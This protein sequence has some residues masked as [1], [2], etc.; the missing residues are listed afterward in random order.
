LSVVFVGLLAAPLA[1]K[2]WSGEASGGTMDRE[3]ALER[4]G[5]VLKNV[6]KEVGIDFTHHAPTLD[7]SLSHIMPEVAQI[8]ASVSV[9]DYDGDGYS[10]LYV[11][12][13]KYGTENALYRN[14]GDG[15]FKNVAPE[16]GL[17]D[18][19]RR[20]MGT[21]MGSVWGDYDNDGDEDLFLYK[22]G[23][24]KLFRNE[25]GTGFTDV[26]DHLKGLPDWMN[27]GTAI[28]LDANQDGFLDLFV[29]GFYPSAF[30]LWNLETTRVMPESY[31][32][33]RNGGQNHLFLNQGDGT[34]REA[35]EEWGLTDT[36][37]TLAAAA[38]DFN[39]S[40]Y[41]DLFIA[42]DFG[43]DQFFVNVEGKRFRAASRASNVGRIPES[44]MNASTGDVMNRGTQALYVS[45]L[46]EEGVLV[47]GNNLWMAGS[48]ESGAIPAFDNLAG[49]MG[50]AQGGWSYGGQFGDLNNDG[51]QD[52]IVVNGFY[53]GSKSASYWYDFSKVAGGNED[54]IANAA[55]WPAMEG[56]SLSGHQQ[57]RIWINDGA[58]QF[59]NVAPAVGGASTHDGRAV[60]LADLQNRGAP[61]AVIANQRGPVEVYRNTVDPQHDWIAFDLTG[62][63][64]NRSAI[65]ARVTLHWNDQQQVQQVHGG[66]GFASQNQR[67]VHFGLGTDPAVQKAVIRWPSGTTQ[68][69]KSPEINTIHDVTEP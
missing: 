52:L 5:F 7:S 61:D 46:T 58:G 34:F 53:S 9:S 63:E 64:S 55:N 11:T 56:R 68:T 40:G 38:S 31:E 3:K 19:N 25:D 67:R 69:I 29:G 42:N 33:A 36:R 21:S 37:W 41:P 18:V 20:G 10:D 35:S 49:T 48:T 39:R 8:G 62:T 1:I 12:N 6:A 30:D 16:L 47:Q 59:Q 57:T 65:G 32:Y 45:N 24:C 26:T 22:W 23:Q 43:A 54:I 60:V 2:Q 17:A 15:T 66:S 4:H 44:G 50:V 27:A 13:S 14:Q 28:W 51:W